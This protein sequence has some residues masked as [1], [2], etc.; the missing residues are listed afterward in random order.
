[1]NNQGYRFARLLWLYGEIISK[2]FVTFQQISE[3]W[4]NSS[5]NRTGSPL[6]H[7]TFENH[8]KDVEDLFGINIECNRADNTYYVLSQ[9]NFAK[10]ACDMLNGA[11]LFN[12]LRFNPQIRD[13]V[14]PEQKYNEDTSKLFKVTEAILESR[15]LRLR[16]RH[17]YDCNRECDYQ[18]KPIAIKQFRNRWYI[19]GELEI[20][21]T[22]SFPLDRVM[23]IKKGDIIESSKLN[24]E[25]LFADSFGIIRDESVKSEEILIKV[26]REQS[27]YFK[28]LPLH[29]SQQVVSDTPEYV[30][31]RLRLAPTYD[32]IMELLSHG[33]KIE[34][35]EPRSLRD[36]MISKIREMTKIYNS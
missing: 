26:E 17:N 11:L 25:E 30:I 13:H 7:K 32:F 9:P 19:I 29:S 35:L 21:N 14:Y 31:F 10:A 8:R 6:S 28:S 23:S 36:T 1:M 27:N 4:A 12:N 3:S 22:Y 15:E 24:V 18:I 34:V 2:G 5:L 20:G 16:Y 33:N